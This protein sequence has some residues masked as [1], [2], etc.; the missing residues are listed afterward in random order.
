MPKL[1]PIEQDPALKIIGLGRSGR[2]DLAENHDKYLVENYKS[3]TA[4]WKPNSKKLRKSKAKPRTSKRL[5][6]QIK[7]SSQ[8]RVKKTK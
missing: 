6:N 5:T 8:N 7:G 3:E 1:I 2:G 4:N